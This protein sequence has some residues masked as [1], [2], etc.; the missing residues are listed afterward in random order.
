MHCHRNSDGRVSE[1]T[2]PP[3]KAAQNNWVGDHSGAVIS[4]R[5]RMPR[6]ASVDGEAVEPAG[7]S[8]VDQRLLAAA[9][10]HMRSIPRRV[11]AQLPDFTR[12]SPL[13]ATR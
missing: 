11:L 4:I 12:Q 10:A 7:A 5:S 8:G 9:L 2:A 3:L 13:I 1:E 6:I